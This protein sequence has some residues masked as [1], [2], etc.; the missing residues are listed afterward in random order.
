MSAPK[1]EE[2]FS[3]LSP[4][5]DLDGA[6]TLSLLRRLMDELTRLFRQELALA[7]AEV[8]DI[9][10]KLATGLAALAAG[11]AVLYAGFLTLLAAAVLGLSI[12]VAPWLAALIVGAAVTLIGLLLLLA[13]RK[14][15]DPSVL[16]PRR[17]AE[18]LQ[19]DKQVLSRSAP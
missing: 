12:V 4:R 11:S 1:R 17:S 9:L 6:S 18:S 10:G 2:D 7:T 8:K 14:A 15:A 13:A 3:T 19:R 5:S 16:K